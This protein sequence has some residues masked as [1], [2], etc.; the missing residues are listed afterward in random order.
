M[1]DP[2][3]HK[4]NLGNANSVTLACDSQEDLPMA[5]SL[6]FVACGALAVKIMQKPTTS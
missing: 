5:G 1:A 2:W 3:S 6:D 4:I